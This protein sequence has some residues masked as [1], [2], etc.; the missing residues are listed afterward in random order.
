MGLQDLLGFIL[1]KAAHQLA[2]AVHAFEGRG[3][4]LGQVSAVQAS[5]PGVL[6]CPEER[7]RR[8]TESRISRVPGWIAVAR[9]CRCRRTS[10]S[11]NRTPIPW[12]ASSQ[13]ANSPE[14]P[15]PTINTSFCV[16]NFDFY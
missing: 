9:A 11:T 13:A 3:A 1:R 6:S 15:A 14:G 2:A 10:L 12:R 7:E 16:I 4:N 5:A 8:P